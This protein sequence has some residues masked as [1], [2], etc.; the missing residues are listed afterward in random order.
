MNRLKFIKLNLP[1][2]VSFLIVLVS[3][4]ITNNIH[5]W[6]TKQVIQ[7]DIIS[8]YGY[9]PAAFI[10]DDITLKFTENYT[11]P[12]QFEM[13]PKEAPN[14][15][16][17]FITSMGMSYMYAPFF[18]AAH[19]YAKNSKFD[20]GGYSE[21]Y[22]LAII[23]S[24]LFFFAFGLFF[25]CKLLLHFFN[26]FISTL[27]ILLT[28][29]GSNLIYY[30]VFEPGMSHTFSFALITMFVWF[31]IKW[32]DNQK[33]F[34]AILL[35]I[36]IGLISL[37]RPTNII[38]SLFFIFFG[39]RSRNDLTNRIP[40]FLS[41]FKHLAL[42][43]F[44]WFLIWFPQFLY[45][46]TLTGSFLYNSYADGSRFFFDNPKIING[47]FSYRN[48]WLVYSPAMIF[49]VLGLFF[50]WRKQKDL[51]VPVLLTFLVFIY[52]TYSWWCWWSGG[53]FGNRFMIDIYGM[54]AL[55]S[56]AFFSY[57]YSLKPKWIKY[58]VF[59]VAFM[60]LFAGVHHINKRR[61]FSFHWD[62]MT[63]EAFWDSYFK[64]KPTPEFEGKLRAPDYEK[65]LQ[66]IDEFSK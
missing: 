39:L 61:N 52:I 24:A 18:F 32:Y 2:I 30:A 29:V 44:F 50:P 31:T 55:S 26:P 53:A 63:R 37:I 12:H 17:V 34:Y 13:W 54:L 47:F 10:Y 51:Q 20:A 60:L 25:L 33:Y 5:L 8:Y 57:I 27:V 41:R 15:S 62:S 6:K 43:I 3:I 38:I 4:N 7:W 28:V 1:Y 9:L 59:V 11:G 48:G 46:K 36:I 58:P 14:G 21:P 16:K 56:G 49:S 45:W 42:I 22:H 64:T 66:G 40:F 65:A 35:G 19:H 23:I